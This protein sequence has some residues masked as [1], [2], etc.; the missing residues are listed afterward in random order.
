MTQWIYIRE[1]HIK[2]IDVMVFLEHQGCRVNVG[3]AVVSSWIKREINQAVLHFL[4]KYM[5]VI[6][7]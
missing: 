5:G 1:K 4:L 2:Y 7:I 3:A 6:V